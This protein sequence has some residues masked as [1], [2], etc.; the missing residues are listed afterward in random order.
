MDI[1]TKTVSVPIDDNYPE[2]LAK[3]QGEGW[4][5]RPDIPPVAV[6]HLIRPKGAAPGVGFAQ[7][8]MKIDDS[9]VFVMG[10]DGVIRKG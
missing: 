1:E 8:E 7:G 4:M 3:L 2:A 10:P 9:R 6:W 5:A